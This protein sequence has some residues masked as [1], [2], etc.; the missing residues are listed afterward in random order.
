MAFFIDKTS[1]LDY[2]YNMIK[3]LI[4]TFL[5][6]CLN[7]N[8]A[9]AIENGQVERSPNR[10]VPLYVEGIMIGCSGYLY[11]PRIVLTAAHCL[12]G[13]YKVTQVGFPN[14]KAGPSNERVSVEKSLFPSLY[15][16]QSQYDNDFAVLVLSKPIPVPYSAELLTETIKDKIVGTNIEVKIS[17]FGNQDTTQ[18]TSQT[19]RDAHYTYAN[20]GSINNEIQLINKEVGSVCSGDSGG[21][22][23]IVYEGKEIYLGATSH[24]WNQPNCGRWGGGGTRSLLFAPVYKYTD[25]IKMAKDIIGPEIIIQTVKPAPTPK[26][27]AVKKCIKLKNG[28]CK[29]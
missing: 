8:S 28:K 10:V 22:N 13:Q 2:T 18:T 3:K 4:V 17:G 19:I 23:T 24:G 29:K 20:L 12:I 7:I 26:P 16:E 11:E 27:V 21:S 14:Q 25:V 15:N 9:S 5:L 1:Q 6:L